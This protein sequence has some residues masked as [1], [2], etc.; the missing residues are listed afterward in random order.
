MKIHPIFQNILDT[1]SAYAIPNPQ[2]HNLSLLLDTGQ[3]AAVHREIL[4][5]QQTFSYPEHFPRKIPILLNM[6]DSDTL[7]L[8]KI[9]LLYLFGF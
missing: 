9:T 3:L 4:I 1:N 7:A 2:V 5:S 6:F 8:A